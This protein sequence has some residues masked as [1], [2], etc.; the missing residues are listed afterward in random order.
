M[1]EILRETSPDVFVSVSHELSREYR[2]YERTSTI[3]ANAYVGRKVSDYL[4]NLDVG[5]RSDGFEGDLMIMQSNGGL[6]DVETARRHC[7]QMMESGPAGGIVGTMA[8]CE[9]LDI[10]SAVSFDMGG[11][12][13]KACVVRRGEPSFSP[14]YFV[15][16]YNEGLVVRIPVLDI[17]EVGTGGGSIAW[18]RRG[19][20][21]ARGPPKRRSRAGA[22]VYGRGGTEPTVTDA[23]VVLGRL[24]PTNFLG[25][26]M[27]LDASTAVA[28]ALGSPCRVTGRGPSSGPH[29]ECWRSRPRR[30]RMRCAASRS[31]RGLDPR[32]FVMFALRGRWTVARRP[33]WQGSCS[34]RRVIIP[35]SPGHFSAVGMLSADLRRDVVQTMV[36]RLNEMTM[37][38]LEDEFRG[39]EAEGRGVLERTGISMDAI[40]FERAADMRYVGQE[41]TVTVRFP[42]RFNTD[43]GVAR[44]ELKALFDEAHELRYSH[45]AEEEPCDIVTLAG[46]RHRALDQAE[47]PG[48]RGGR[49]GAAGGRAA[50]P[51]DG[52]LRRGGTTPDP[53]SRPRSALLAGNVIDGPAVVE[54]TASTTIV[55]PGD[56]VLVNE[57]GHLIIEIGGGAR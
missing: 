47:H 32:D 34:I 18:L 40:V 56:R 30:W 23:N 19:G 5:L 50:R 28:A 41:H 12:T 10:E 39:L 45:S 31:Q 6:S 48:D 16:G 52:R 2:E 15:G 55:D 37:A 1:A 7:M 36:R 35:V 3:A 17:V 20:R 29:R 54:E 51:P 43:D 21:S 27:E 44:K 8:L 57:Y 42:N 46:L 38:D 26:E 14:D 25:G 11:T 9:L 13:A 4:S 33:R 53:R 24:E 22:R 49:R